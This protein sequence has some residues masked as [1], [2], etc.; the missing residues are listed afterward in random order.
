VG[1][2][3]EIAGLGRGV[4]VAGS[5]RNTEEELAAARRVLAEHDAEDLLP[6]LG[7][8]HD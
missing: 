7:L 1:G 2:T 6:M 3:D 4:I 5:V 8:D